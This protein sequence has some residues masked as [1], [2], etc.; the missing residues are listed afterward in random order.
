MNKGMRRILRWKN[1][2][3][4]PVQEVGEGSDLV[5]ERVPAGPSKQKEK[6]RM[7]SMMLCSDEEEQPSEDS[8]MRLI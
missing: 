6:D 1:L 2:A 3:V 5:K 7:V 8:K 4:R